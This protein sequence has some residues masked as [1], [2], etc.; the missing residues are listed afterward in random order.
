MTGVAPYGLVWAIL[1]YAWIANY[2]IRMAL[3]A[4]L[5]PI[6]AEFGLTYAQAGLLSAAV[7]YAY[8]SMQLPAGALG[9]RLGRRRMVIAGVLLSAGASVF[10]GLAG[11]LT[12]LFVARLA[13]GLSQGF[14]FSND[15]VIIAATTPPGRIALGQGISFSG[16]GLGTTLGLVLAGYLG[17]LLPWRHVFL[18]FAFPPLLAALM[19]WRWIP[20]PPRATAAA[21]PAWPFQR[22]LRTRDFWLLAISGMVP[23]Y[24]QFLLA[25]W[26]PALFVEAGVRDLARSASLASLQGLTAPAGLLVSGLATD[27]LRARGY[28]GKLVIAAA[29]SGSV[30]TVLAMGLIIRQH[31][32]AWLLTL[33]LLGTSFFIWC[34]W[35]PAYAILGDLFPSSVLG[36]AFGAFNTICFLGAVASPFVTGWL[37]DLTGSF[38]AGLHGAAAL[39][40]LAVAG[41]MSLDRPFRAAAGPAS[42]AGRARS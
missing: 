35:G 26:G 18:L 29:L 24:V 31:G 23:I 11:T 40:A 17:T 33:A 7:F 4:L 27:R 41:M 12:L 13:T 15:R 20:E 16:P 42:V 14:L 1:V 2:L 30:L 6:M 34:C 36:R 10:T 8:T 32:H 21:D 38:V 37:R 9:D 5:P 22:V 28:H 39:S 25:T 19:I 3:S